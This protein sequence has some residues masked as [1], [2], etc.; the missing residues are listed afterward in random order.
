MARRR[1]FALGL[2]AIAAY[3]CGVWIASANGTG[4]RLPLLDGLTRPQFYYYVCPPPGATSTKKPGSASG[5]LPLNANGSGG[6]YIAPQP[7]GQLQLILSTG[8][9]APHAPDTSVHISLTPEC[10]TG[11]PAPPSG[12]QVTGNVYDITAKYLPSGD[13]ATLQK[14]A[15]MIII[16]PGQATSALVA[17]PTHVL[18]EDTNGTWTRLGG[19][20]SPGSLQVGDNKI[21]SLGRFAVMVASKGG[22]SLLP[23]ILGVV[24]AGIALALVIA[25]ASGAIGPLRK[26]EPKDEP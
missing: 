2:A 17:P 22:R 9:F 26:R 6:S 10:P 1:T 20:D 12:L 25:F 24:A 18:Y 8:A 7:D 4:Q 11:A 19:S 3:A 5:D 14:P 16:Y 21:T 13:P 23:A 15:G